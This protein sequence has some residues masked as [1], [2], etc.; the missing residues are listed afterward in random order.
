LLVNSMTAY[1]LSRLR[2]PG[3]TA[4]PRA[5]RSGARNA[6]GAAG[7]PPAIAVRLAQSPLARLAWRLRIARITSQRMPAG[8]SRNT[9]KI[10]M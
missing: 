1:A 10:R 5:W 2:W 4:L 9:E 8:T 3:P 6:Q 7:P